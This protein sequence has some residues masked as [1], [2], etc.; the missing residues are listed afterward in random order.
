MDQDTPD[1]PPTW[2]DV[3]P[4]PL[5]GLD[6]DQFGAYLVMQEL[7][8]SSIR[9][10][11]PMFVRWVDWAHGEGHD[12]YRPCPLAV[13]AWSK[14]LQGGRSSL[15]HA[16]AMIRHLCEALGVDDVS[17]AIT[18][19]RQPRRQHRGLDDERATKLVEAAVRMG[20][21]GTAVLVSLYTGGRVS[22]VASLSWF[23]VDLDGGFIRLVRTKT[24]DVHTLPLH[25]NLAEH[26][27][28]RRVP[29][30]QW[31]FP[32]RYGGHL[33]PAR[34]REWIAEVAAEAGVGKVTPHQL[35]HTAITKAYHATKDL[36]AA[37]DFAG[38]TKV[39][40][41]VRYTEVHRDR[42]AAAVN[43]LDWHGKLAAGA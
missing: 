36:R 22:E 23:N 43:A 24:G 6:V 10:Y 30:E 13:R 9:V 32:G 28:A 25:P 19:P 16:R 8:D 17:P 40:T 18:L 12:P 26:L 27:A 15:A 35:R 38:H 31:V 1:L 2:E 7:A 5:P 3:A 37:Q 33:S 41:T 34:I 39:E 14:T 21:K 42:L 20:L 4:A 29:G 11:R